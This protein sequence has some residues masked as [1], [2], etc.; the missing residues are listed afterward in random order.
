MSKSSFFPEYLLTCIINVNLIDKIFSVEFIQNIFIVVIQL[1]ITF[2]VRYFFNYFDGK[3][4][5]KN[6]KQ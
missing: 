5:T 4:K 2:L 3:N 6:N 1:L